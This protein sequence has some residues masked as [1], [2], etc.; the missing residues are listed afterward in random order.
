M[1]WVDAHENGKHSYKAKF[2]VNGQDMKAEFAADGSLIKE[3][4]ND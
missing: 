4:E 2:K 1:E 3:K